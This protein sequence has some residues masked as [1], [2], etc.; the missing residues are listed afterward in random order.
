MNDLKNIHFYI[1]DWLTSTFLA[2]LNDK[3]LDL[4]LIEQNTD[5]TNK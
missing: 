4:K 2:T 3:S 1:T 5:T